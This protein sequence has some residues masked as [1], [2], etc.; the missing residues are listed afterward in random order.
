MMML[1][2]QATSTT[3]TQIIKEYQTKYTHK[4]K[5]KE[6]NNLKLTNLNKTN[7][8]KLKPHELSN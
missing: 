2:M 4:L 6:T 3:T 1:N 7:L 5:T 8:N